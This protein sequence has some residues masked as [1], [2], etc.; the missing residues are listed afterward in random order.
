MQ[1]SEPLL[2][3]NLKTGPCWI[4]TLSVV[5]AT[6]VTNRTLLWFHQR[7]CMRQLQLFLLLHPRHL[8]ILDLCLFLFV[9]FC[10]VLFF[11]SPRPINTVAW[12][13]SRHYS[14]LLA[15]MDVSPGGLATGILY[16]WRKICPES[17]HELSL[18]YISSHWN[19][20]HEWLFCDRFVAFTL[21][22]LAFCL[23]PV[24]CKQDLK[25]YNKW[26]IVRSSVPWDKGYGPGPLPWIGH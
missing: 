23:L 14:S 18:E 12:E 21:T 26:R 7:T 25:Q 6:T 1:N 4:V 20:F 11:N 13:N 16:W 19:I 5:L 2:K 24:N 10:F 22:F 17:T 9:L 15:T 8:V 3:H